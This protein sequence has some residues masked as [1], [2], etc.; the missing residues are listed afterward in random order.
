MD[1]DDLIGRRVTKNTKVDIVKGA[2][3]A[4]KNYGRVRHSD[5]TIEVL[6]KE[7]RSI[8]NGVR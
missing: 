6:T 1:G 5:T 8:H 2:S 3:I 4:A 7:K